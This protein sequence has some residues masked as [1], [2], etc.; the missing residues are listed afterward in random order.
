MDKNSLSKRP[1]LI[2]ITM[3]ITHLFIE[4]YKNLK[5]Y[6]TINSSAGEIELYVNLFNSLRGVCASNCNLEDFQE[7]LENEKKDLYAILEQV[8]KDKTRPYTSLKAEIDLLTDLLMDS[9]AE[10]KNPDPLIIK[11]HDK[12][13]NTVGLLE[14]P[15]ESYHK[16]FEELGNLFPN[17]IEYDKLIDLVASIAEKR[18]SELVSGKIF[19]QRAGQKYVNNYIKESIVFFGKA[20]LKLAKDESEY[21]LSL[22]LRGMGYAYSN[23]GL[24]WAS[25]SCFVSANFIAFKS[26][27]S[28]REA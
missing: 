20:V 10:N 26:W 15:F 18:S 9:V 11:L 17:N 1:G 24:Y 3:M 8:S 14:F 22:A 4:E 21:E 19:L 13:A 27:A 7:N 2:Y 28:T 5:Q 23:L 6:I 16:I 12:L 25:N